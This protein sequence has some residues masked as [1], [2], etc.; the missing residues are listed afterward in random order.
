MPEPKKRILDAQDYNG[1]E[2]IFGIRPEDIHAEQIALNTFS[3]PTVKPTIVVSELT[4][5]ETILY[6]D[7]AGTEIIAVVDA[8]DY[9]APGREIDIAFNMNRAHFFDIET[10]NAIK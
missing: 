8:R 4:G 9:H 5:A 3:T 10:D 2:V 7:I 1:K 6:L